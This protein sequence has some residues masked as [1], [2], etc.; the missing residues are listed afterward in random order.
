MDTLTALCVIFLSAYAIIIAFAI[1]EY[2]WIFTRS[3]F[4]EDM[5][6]KRNRRRGEQRWT[7]PRLHSPICS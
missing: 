6:E 4:F 2:A 3:A 1:K 7:I 5:R